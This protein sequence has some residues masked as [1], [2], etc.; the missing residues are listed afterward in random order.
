MI[1]LVDPAFDKTQTQKY[2]L[3]VLLRPDGYSL[4]VLDTRTS[5]FL[6]LN[7]EQFLPSN[8]ATLPG[9]EY[10]Q[11]HYISHFRKQ[12]LIKFSYGQIDLVYA[13]PK[14]TLVPPGFSKEETIEEYFRFNH[15]LSTTEKI[16]SQQ[17][18]VGEMTA[19]YAIP[20]CIENLSNEWFNSAYPGSSASVFIQSLLK[21]NAHILARQ[22]FLNVWGS[23]FDI[24]VIQGRKLLYYNTFR[25]QA[26]DDLVYFVIYVLE[27]MGFVPAEELV[28]LMGDIN[29]DS[30]EYKLLHQFVYKLHFAGM[31]DLAEFSPVF[32]E[33]LVHRFYTLFNL[34]FCE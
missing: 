9:N 27:Q 25:K 13:S 30:E 4:C 23:Y 5:L 3:S 26:A 22:V 16:K 8:S 19:I 14:V 7:D 34:P 24:A 29:A 20:A 6:A 12:E 2:R 21:D 28:F 31:H 15:P 10:L 33:I 11:D 32:S 1:N 17:V 18:P